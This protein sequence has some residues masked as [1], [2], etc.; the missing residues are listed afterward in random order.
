MMQVEVVYASTKKQSALSVLLSPGATV[1]DAIIASGLLIHFPEIDL[2]KNT[3]GIWGKV[4]SLTTP[5]EPGDR[6]EIYRPLTIDPKEARRARSRLRG[7]TNE[8]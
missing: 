4:V 3:V 6:V 2:Q 5:V 1:Q 8:T 7:M